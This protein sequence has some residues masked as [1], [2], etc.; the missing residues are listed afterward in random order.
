MQNAVRTNDLQIMGST[1]KVYMI[2]HV[3]QSKHR[4]FHS[5]V[6]F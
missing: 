4:R 6:L 1:R 5:A 3:R 2:G